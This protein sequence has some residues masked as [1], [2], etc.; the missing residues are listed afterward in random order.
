MLNK[1]LVVSG[2]L[3]SARRQAGVLAL[4]GRR[5]GRDSHLSSQVNVFPV[6]GL[7]RRESRGRRSG[8]GPIVEDDVCIQ[9]ATESMQYSR[10]NLTDHS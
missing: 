2:F 3:P 7:G 8:L 5:W 10:L 4:S 1:I 9:M 6:L